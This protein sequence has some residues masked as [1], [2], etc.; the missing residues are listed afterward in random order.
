MAEMLTKFE[1]YLRGEK[2]LSEGTVA[3]YLRDC[4]EFVD[5]CGT[6]PEDFRPASVTA[7][8]FGGWIM[9][10]TKQKKVVTSGG[11]K[12]REPLYKASSVNTKTSSLKVLFRWLH[13]SGH[14]ERNPLTASKQLKT[15][16]LLPT[17]IPE[18]RMM[19]LVEELVERSESEDFEVRRNAVLV[20]LFYCTGLRLA[21]VTSLTRESF[22]PSLSHVRVVGKG[23]KERIVPIVSILRSVLKNFLAFTAENICTNGENSLFLTSEGKPMSRYQIERAVQRLLGEWGIEGKHSP[24]VLR[25]TFATLLL[26]RGADIREIQELLGHS[27]LQ[28]TQ[29]Y[30]HNNISRLKSIYHS[31]HPRGVQNSK[32]KIQN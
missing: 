6:T 25:H 11:R 32:F 8:D 17:Y 22:T 10:L 16:S 12:H 4:R 15:P 2:R 3:H 1:E 20:L 27:S 9:H 13:D 18:E 21:E 23:Q 14:I 24:H 28:T 7:D 19:R 30:T 29:I 5:W 31:A 26:E